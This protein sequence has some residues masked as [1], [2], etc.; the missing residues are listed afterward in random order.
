MKFHRIRLRGPWKLEWLDSTAEDRTIIHAGE[1]DSSSGKEESG[2]TQAVHLPTK[3]S[4][5][6]SRQSGR[7][8]LTR[9]FH[10]PTNLG[11]DEVVA[12]VF[13]A[14][15]FQATVSLNGRAL[16]AATRTRE[17][18]RFEVTPLLQAGNE[19][20]IEMEI[21]RA[22]VPEPSADWGDVALEISRS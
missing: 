12:I 1:R 4:A 16:I 11:P 17:R 2:A 8:R 9:R 10:K 5:I 22:T 6:F 3:W 13:A 20:V 14:L 15:P 7:V 18:S 21:D 19:L